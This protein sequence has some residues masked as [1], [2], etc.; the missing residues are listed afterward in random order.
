[1]TLRELITLL[2]IE[3]EFHE[4]GTPVTVMLN[5]DE[6]GPLYYESLELEY[7]EEHGIVLTPKV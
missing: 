5:H 6:W 4:D 7:D 2:N 3:S 1:M